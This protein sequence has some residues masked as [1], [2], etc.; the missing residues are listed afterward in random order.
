MRLQDGKS[1]NDRN[2]ITQSVFDGIAVHG[3]DRNRCCKLVM[4]L[5]DVLVDQLVVKQPMRP[6]EQNFLRPKAHEKLEADSRKAR[7]FSRHLEAEPIAQVINQM[8]PTEADDL[9]D[10]HDDEC[11][12]VQIKIRSPSKALLLLTFLIFSLSRSGLLSG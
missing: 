9:V 5:V 2:D 7:K 6:V 4:H 1:G 3:N 12:R 10:N 8:R 11:L